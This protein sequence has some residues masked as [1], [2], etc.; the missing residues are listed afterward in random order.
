MVTH[1]FDNTAEAARKLACLA[2]EKQAARSV[3]RK[4]ANAEWLNT[5]LQWAK[6][7]PEMAGSLLGLTGGG[8]FGALSSLG[9]DEDERNTVGSAMTGA[10]GG[11][12][13]GLGS[14]LAYRNRDALGRTLGGV[15]GSGG[16][17]APR[18]VSDAIQRGIDRG[19]LP[20]MSPAEQRDLGNRL[21]RLPY[22][23]AESTLSD[24]MMRV[25]GELQ[26]QRQAH[27][28]TPS[29][30]PWLQQILRIAD[31]PTF[32]EPEWAR[33]PEAAGFS[34]EQLTALAKAR[35]QEMQKA[36][37]KDMPGIDT[38]FGMS[39]DPYT[40]GMAGA[41]DVGHSALRRAIEARNPAN[42]VEG[43]EV[44][45]EA[46]PQGGDVAKLQEHLDKLR[47]SGTASPEAVTEAERML[48]ES[49]RAQWARRASGPDVR[50]AIGEA[51]ASEHG[52]A[53]GLLDRTFGMGKGRAGPG[54]QQV[55]QQTRPDLAGPRP[56]TAQQAA[57][58]ATE[59]GEVM[60]WLRNAERQGRANRGAYVGTVESINFPRPKGSR[61]PSTGVKPG[62]MASPSRRNLIGRGLLYGALPLAAGH[63]RRTGYI[64][65]PANYTPEKLLGRK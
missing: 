11:G 44:A 33:D 18:T 30:P 13:L 57:A 37:D 63:I 17:P 28:K 43:A 62:W 59:E 60:Q 53:R 48:G 1:L 31:T 47:S 45:R 5:V 25:Y 64:Y 21:G 4:Q 52:G 14:G 35:E 22:S 20:A 27:P 2:M 65:D 38:G 26:R 9:R 61:L 54:V 7:N 15:F 34:G 16:E 3:R 40:A 49:R 6:E 12:L 55:I 41:A 56:L 39:W 42:L 51:Y 50:R 32:Q 29:S 46:L 19:D 23:E 8:L 10:L 36:F 24:P 58:M